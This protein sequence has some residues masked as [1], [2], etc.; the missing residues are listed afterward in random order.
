MYLGKIITYGFIAISFV[1]GP[2]ILF[3]VPD[4]TPPPVSP[5]ATPELLYDAAALSSASLTEI[6]FNF[7]RDVVAYAMGPQ[8]Y[9][10]FSALPPNYPN[11]C[12]MG[13]AENTTTN[14]NSSNA[15]VETRRTQNL[16]DTCNNDTSRNNARELARQR[17]KE[18]ELLLRDEN[19]TQ[20][21]EN[22]FALA[23]AGDPNF[24]RAFE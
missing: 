23:I 20:K 21:E 2:N 14:S 9:S 4:T 1:A 7:N 13:G 3:A 16:R 22:E 10:T 8:C 6:N 24:V 15:A 18:G 19:I 12:S 5:P 17:T 11:M